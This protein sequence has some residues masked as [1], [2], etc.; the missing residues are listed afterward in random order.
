MSPRMVTP[1][2]KRGDRMREGRGF[3]RG[4]LREVGLSPSEAMRLGIPVDRR[5]RTVHGE[6]VE[7]LRAYLEESEKSGIRFK[8]PRQTAKPKRGRVFRGLTSAGKKMR[9]LRKRGP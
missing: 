4:E 2:I 6:N 7:R 8:K 3:S 9:G 1:I 5:R